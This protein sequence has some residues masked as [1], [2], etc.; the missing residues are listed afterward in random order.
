MHASAVLTGRGTRREDRRMTPRPLAA[1]VSAMLLIQSAWG[2][3]VPQAAYAAPATVLWTERADF[4]YNA[5]SL[6]ATATRYQVDTVTSPGDVKLSG[7]A[8]TAGVGSYHAM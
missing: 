6:D 3:A 2:L 5:S 8:I 1:L 7:P 4:E